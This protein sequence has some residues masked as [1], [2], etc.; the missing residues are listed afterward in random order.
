LERTKPTPMGMIF[1]SAFPFIPI[2][3]SFSLNK[4]HQGRICVATVTIPVTLHLANLED[5][6]DPTYCSTP[7]VRYNHFYHLFCCHRFLSACQPYIYLLSCFSSSTF[8]PPRHCHIP[9]SIGESPP[10]AVH[11]GTLSL[12]FPGLS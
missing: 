1:L 8:H 5:L 4:F 2:P 10:F 12:L 11:T 6:L 9:H 3:P 7:L